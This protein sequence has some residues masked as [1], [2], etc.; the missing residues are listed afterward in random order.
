MVLFVML[1]KAQQIGDYTNFFYKPMLYNPAYT[2]VQNNINATAITRLQWSGFTNAP[3]F[4][5]F[6]LD[7]KFKKKKM[8]LGLN[9]ISDKQGLTGRTGGD[10]L[11]SYSLTLNKRNRLAFGVSFG[12]I[13][14][15]LSFSKA[16]VENTNDP[17]LSTQSQSKITIDGSAGIALIGKKIELGFSVPQLIGHKLKYNT[18]SGTTSTYSQTPQYLTYLR[19][20][21][22]VDREKGISLSP[23]ALIRYVPH[24]PFQFNAGL[25]FDW[26]K[27]LALAAIYKSDYAMA[28]SAGFWIY[29]HLNVAYSYDFVLGGIAKYSGQ[30]HEIL[31]SYTFGKDEEKEGG[32]EAD[33]TNAAKMKD[34][35][36]VLLENLL[37]QIDLIFENKNATKE[38]YRRLID[39]INQF[40]NSHFNDPVLKKLARDY[41]KKLLELEK[42]SD[43]DAEP[44]NVTVKGQIGLTGGKKSKSKPDFSD[45]TVQLMDKKTGTLIGLYIPKTRNGKYIIILE[46]GKKYIIKVEKEG[47]QT[48]SKEM[49]PPVRKTSYEI[50][51]AIRLKKSKAVKAPV[52]SNKYK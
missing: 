17:I 2:G 41:T 51:Q 45:I 27:K 42:G 44:I 4:N 13:D 47:Y 16:V 5:A 15:T 37:A 10:I 28:V 30:T 22:F 23:M 6:T 39:R 11:Y 31:L 14:N 25:I 8:A 29:K 43:S 3:Q 49:S 19:Y 12:L 46:P 40:S 33:S 50:K 35:N 52:K 9:L 21:Y 26:K 24:S 34:L 1:L 7:G 48:V 18:E 38:D 32:T 36:T 20:K